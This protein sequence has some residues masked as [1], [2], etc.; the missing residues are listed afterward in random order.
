MIWRVQTRVNRGLGRE[1][2][3]LSSVDGALFGSR[4]LSST[5]LQRG[6]PKDEEQCETLL[7]PVAD[8]SSGRTDSLRLLVGLLV[9]E[10]QAM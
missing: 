6:V 3:P 7:L 8:P 5:C 9:W 10:H 2:G 4:A 1:A